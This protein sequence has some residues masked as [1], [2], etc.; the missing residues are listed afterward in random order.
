LLGSEAF[1]RG[2][3]GLRRYEARPEKGHSTRS[4]PRS[5]PFGERRLRQPRAPQFKA[6]EKGEVRCADG[7]DP[8]LFYARVATALGTSDEHGINLLMNHAPTA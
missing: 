4:P 2:R 5:A 7:I 3:G 8:D 1:P 6:N